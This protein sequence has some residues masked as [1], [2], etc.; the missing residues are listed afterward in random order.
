M[1]LLVRTQQFLRADECLQQTQ[2]FNLGTQESSRVYGRW[3]I[4]L[5]CNFVIS[6]NKTAVFLCTEIL[7]TA[8]L[9]SVMLAFLSVQ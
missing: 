6:T 7:Q 4:F 1:V 2:M 8:T 3:D 9:N 5:Y